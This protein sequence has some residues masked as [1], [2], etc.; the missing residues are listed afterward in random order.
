MNESSRR[1]GHFDER[2]IAHG[3]RPPV[4]LA[5][6]DRWEDEGGHYVVDWSAPSG[7]DW[8]KFR[9]RYFHRRRRHDFEALKAY[10][11]Y[12]PES[13]GEALRLQ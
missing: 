12:A 1:H 9:R 6:V 3:G 11:A 7:L 5:A 10:E 2:W 13:S 4:A 8:A